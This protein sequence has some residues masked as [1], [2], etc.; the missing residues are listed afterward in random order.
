MAPRRWRQRAGPA[1]AAAA[2]R[3]AA[4]LAA[5]AA[6]AAALAA[7]AAARV[8]DGSGC[9]NNCGADATPPR[10]WC[11]GG[12]VPTCACV[13]GFA[14][15]DCS[16]R[17]C[18]AARA[19][20]DGA[21][22]STDA[23]CAARG[24][25]AAGGVC[26]CDSG[27]DGAAC[28]R[29]ACPGGDPPCSGHGV[30]TSV[31]AAGRAAAQP[32]AYAGWDADAVHGCVC[33]PGWTG[34]DCA[35]AACPAGADPL[36]RAG[37]ATHSVTAALLDTGDGPTREVQTI[38]LDA[39]YPV[40]AAGGAAG[41]GSGGPADVDAVQEVSFLSV[42]APAEGTFTLSLDCRAPAC[43]LW[44]ATRRA[45]G[46]TLP[47]AIV[48]GDAAATAAAVHDALEELSFVGAGQVDVA[49]VAEADADTGAR[50]LAFRVTFSGAA[51][52]GA[53]P[54][55]VL[56][57]SGVSAPAGGAMT[58]A[59]V[60]HAVVG[61][62]FAGTVRVSWDDAASAPSYATF[63]SF[64]CTDGADDAALAPAGVKYAE[65]DAAAE[66]DAV[67]DALT[68]AVFGCDGPGATSCAE[69]PPPGAIAVTRTVSGGPWVVWTVTFVA[70]IRTRGNVAP[71][72]PAP[73]G[74]GAAG[75]P[76][77]LVSPTVDL[78]GTAALVTVD[79]AVP[80]V[81]MIGSWA[82]RV[83]F[84]L[85]GGAGPDLAP[86]VG[87]FPWC[88]DGTAVADALVALDADYG[89][90]L[91]AVTRERVGVGA[92]AGGGGAADGAASW[93][94]T[95]AWRVTFLSAP[96]DP[97]PVESSSTLAPSAGPGYAALTVSVDRGVGSDAA[98]AEVQLIDCACPAC[99]TLAHGV[100]LTVAGAG[101]TAL[102]PHS[103]SPAAVRAALAALPGVPDVIVRM[104]DS[105]SGTRTTL[106]D[107]DGTT[108]AVTFAWHSGRPPPLAVAAPRDVTLPPGATFALLRAPAYGAYGG[109]RARAATRPVLPCSGRGTCS[110]G[111]CDCY[112]GFGAGDGGLW[113]D[114]AAGNGSDGGVGFAG[115]GDVIGQCGRAVT[116]PMACPVDC[117]GHGVC[118]GAPEWRCACALGWEGPAC[119][120]PGGVSCGAGPAW[121]DVPHR[122][123]NGR[124][125]VAHAPVPCS[126]HGWC[127]G[128]G[129]CVCEDGWS[130]PACAQSA[131]PGA[132]PAVAGAPP[133]CGNG[134][135]C[136]T[137]RE[138]S[139]WAGGPEYGGWDADGLR[140][141][142]CA[143]PADP[144]ADAPGGPPDRRAWGGHDCLSAVCAGGPDPQ[145]VSAMAAVVA[146]GAGIQAQAVNCT[147]RAGRIRLTLGGGGDGGGGAPAATTRWLR[148]DAWV[149]D[150][151]TP[152]DWV[153][154]GEVGVA[155]ALRALSPAAPPRVAL[156][157]AR[158]DW[159]R[160]CDP[161][162]G[163]VVAVA[164][165]GASRVVPLLT[166]ELD[167]E[168]AASAAASGGRVT[169]VETAARALAFHECN[170][171][172]VCVRRGV[173]AGTCT[174]QPQFGP[175]DGAG[176]PGALPD[177][178]YRNPLI[179]WDRALP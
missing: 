29:S 135:A 140:G 105:V 75:N 88:V 44:G 50:R 162:G 153:V 125:V 26:V 159:R 56:E 70:G 118:S 76:L 49:G 47:I 158:P 133:A 156:T 87:P 4:A 127:A 83:P 39:A 84:V 113:P 176:G 178:G 42:G 73:G 136:I 149:D 12:L 11:S 48:S 100:R 143:A 38:R 7:A 19:W 32:V 41:S 123:R 69:A 166:V 122:G 82:L 93:L 121:F 64:A 18:P 177:C 91:F 120:S 21:G 145:D 117:S 96:D 60:S 126:G 27:F 106:C 142:S 80:G 22:H 61:S 59:T 6:A 92:G 17:V 2:P 67:A 63:H 77:T 161:A 43:P 16:E 150:A 66:A 160:L 28:A 168:A 103:A 102:I 31:G 68:A 107:A 128:G 130:G 114:A 13:D 124:G 169:V 30:C 157:T 81:F 10:G 74:G 134:R 20:F 99:S 58:A 148:W 54:L 163:S 35:T 104:Y 144:D 24:W 97:P 119:G 110:D 85:P 172:G 86:P 36:S 72:V 52:P 40:V 164:F 112:D 131:C 37:L 167:D 101:T 155:S 165:P 179:G 23:P 14:G 111:M 57:A 116:A 171:R 9:P 45:R 33:D 129:G 94:G 173:R 95:Y 79:E 71:F 154:T 53:V 8:D 108:T 65:W 174:C 109:P 78:N 90:G 51:V 15:P 152:L 62:A 55:L 137:M 5:A 138:R 115:A 146:D 89:T 3:A 34:T 175:S 170:R 46:T 132:A 25:C 147:L 141:C 151:D 98:L 139:T 1:S